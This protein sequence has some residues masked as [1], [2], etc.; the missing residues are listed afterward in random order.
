MLEFYSR[1]AVAVRE[2]KAA[3]REMRQGNRGAAILEK[4]RARVESGFAG[5]KPAK[6]ASTAVDADSDVEYDESRFDKRP[7]VAMHVASL[8]GMIARVP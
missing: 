4:L 5:A 7:A 1:R 6:A 8:V 3:A 2:A